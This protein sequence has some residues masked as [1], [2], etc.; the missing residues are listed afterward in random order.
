MR[1]CAVMF[2]A[3]ME[4]LESASL[5]EG[6]LGKQLRDRRKTGVGRRRESVVAQGGVPLNEGTPPPSER[7]GDVDHAQLAQLAALEEEDDES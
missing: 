1:A 2:S 3:W 6:A 4:V 7:M 5:H